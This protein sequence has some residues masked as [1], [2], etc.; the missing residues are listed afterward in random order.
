[1]KLLDKYTLNELEQSDLDEIRLYM[2]ECDKNSTK[3]CQDL[4]KRYDRLFDMLQKY[5]DNKNRK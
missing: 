3:E 1:M 4:I 2:N 5:I